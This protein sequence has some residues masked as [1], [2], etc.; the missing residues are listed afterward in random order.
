[1][2]EQSRRVG[3][4]MHLSIVATPDGEVCFTPVFTMS[5]VTHAPHIC[6]LARSYPYHC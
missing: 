1:M 5:S 2:E 3:L 4:C 6:T